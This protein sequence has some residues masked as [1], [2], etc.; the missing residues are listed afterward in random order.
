MAQV[1]KVDYILAEC[2]LAV[3][4][5]VGSEKT[6]D[7]DAVT[8]WHR[9]YR[10]GLPTCHD[11]RRRLVGGRSPAGDGGRAVSRPARVGGRRR[12]RHHRPCGGGAGLGR[13]RAR[14]PNERDPRICYSAD[15]TISTMTAFSS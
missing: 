6:V 5:A 14:L 9:R 2:F 7:F 11:D 13:D 3:G 1:A 15:C 8:W 4:Q 12:W 10:A